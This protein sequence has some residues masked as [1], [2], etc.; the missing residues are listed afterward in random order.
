MVFSEGALGFLNLSLLLLI[1]TSVHHLLSSQSIDLLFPELTLDLSLFSSLVSM[2]LVDLGLARLSHGSDRSLRLVFDLVTISAI[3]HIVKHLVLAHL[4]FFSRSDL[5]FEDLLEV[6]DVIG[7]EFRH[8]WHSESGDIRACS[9]CLH[10]ELL[11]VQ[12]V[13]ELFLDLIQL[14]SVLLD[15]PLLLFL[16]LFNLRFRSLY[17][18][19]KEVWINVEILLGDLDHILYL[20]VLLHDLDE[21]LPEAL[22]LSP[23]TSLLLLSDLKLAVLLSSEFGLLDGVNG[24]VFDVRGS[25]GHVE[26]VNQI[27]SI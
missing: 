15:F 23:H 19:V 3:F 8:L 16:R 7:E 21:S 2:S 22:D 5:A 9:H 1:L 18:H 17:Q 20:L 12:V 26:R 11:E 27:G 10:C 4:V 13:V 6:I 14:D 25:S 24:L